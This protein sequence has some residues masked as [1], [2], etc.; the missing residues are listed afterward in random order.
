MQRHVLKAKFTSDL[1]QAFHASAAAL[2][3]SASLAHVYWHL[4]LQG[5]TCLHVSHASGQDH[6]LIQVA[7]S[8]L[9]YRSAGQQWHSATT[10]VARKSFWCRHEDGRQ[11]LDL[12]ARV[13]SHRRSFQRYITLPLGQIQEVRKPC[14]PGSSVAHSRGAMTAVSSSRAWL[15]LVNVRQSDEGVVYACRRWAPYV[16]GGIMLHPKGRLGYIRKHA[17]CAAS[18]SQE[19][20]RRYGNSHLILL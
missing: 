10:C 3:F 18:W 1:V 7:T 17:A 13:Y 2:W 12:L 5:K 20:V 6:I 14:P 8:G 15:K 9:Q 19:I 4:P 11:S 16:F